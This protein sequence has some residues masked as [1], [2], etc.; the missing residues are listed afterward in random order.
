MEDKEM[1]YVNPEYV[2]IVAVSEDII[3]S[4]MDRVTVALPEGTKYT[5]T[6]DIYYSNT[7]TGEIEK[8]ETT[9]YLGLDALGI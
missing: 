3:T 9:I 5:Q 7:A 6:E 8:K 4:S 1:K 2:S